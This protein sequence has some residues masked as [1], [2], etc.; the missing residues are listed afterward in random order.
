L[1]KER[2]RHIVALDIAEMD[3]D[4]SKDGIAAEINEA[5]LQYQ[6]TQRDALQKEYDR[7][8]KMYDDLSMDVRNQLEDEQR[9]V[10]ELRDYLR[11][12]E[13]DKSHFRMEIDHLKADPSMTFSLD[14]GSLMDDEIRVKVKEVEEAE[15]SRRSA[16]IELDRMYDNWRERIDRSID[17]AYIKLTEPDDKY[18]LSEIKKYMIDNDR[19]TRSLNALLSE[20][21]KLENLLYLRKT[22]TRLSSTVRIDE[23]SFGSRF[24][25]IKKE[26]KELMNELNK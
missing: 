4:Q 5:N 8:T 9:E 24:G 13:T 22:N 2:Q 10:E 23:K 18:H 11:K 1:K 12:L 21:E 19:A 16:E 7:V 6:R 15:K 3:D 14:G 20:K 25:S 26:D 17:D